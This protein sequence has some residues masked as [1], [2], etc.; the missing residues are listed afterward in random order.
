MD[1]SYTAWKLAFKY[2]Q[3]P[4]VIEVGCSMNVSDV[5]TEGET[6][7]PKYCGQPLTVCD[8]DPI[9]KDIDDV[10]K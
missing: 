6:P 7:L 4:T 9:C 2:A 8:Q 10:V 1:T 5:S 3:Q